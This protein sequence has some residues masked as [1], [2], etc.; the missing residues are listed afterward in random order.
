MATIT[1]RPG[2]ER[3]VIQRHPW[4]F[5]GAIAAV[6]GDPVGGEAVDVLAPTGDWLARG[7]WSGASQ[8][9]VRL[10]AWDPSQL[11]DEAWLRARVARAVSGR[12]GMADGEGGACRLVFSE[13]DGLPGLIVDRYGVYLVIQILTQGMEARRAEVLRALVDLLAPRGIFERSDN[14]M[15]EKESL[16]P[17][18][19]LLWGAEPPD[20]IAL[21]PATAVGTAVAP[22]RLLADLRAGQKTGFYLDQSVNRARVAAYCQGKQVLDC[23]AYS[24]GFSAYAA[25]AGAASLTLIDTSPAALDLARQNLALNQIATPADYV[26]GN[27]FKVLRAFRAEGRRFDVIILDPPKFANSQG[28][29]D[30]AARGYKDINWVAMQLLNPGGILATFSCSGLI[31]PDLFQKIVFGASV[32]AGR[33]VQIIE[34]LAQSP[35]HPV[36]L[37]FPESEYLKG[38][39]CRVW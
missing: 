15:R 12:V 25:R 5:S 30:H 29:V 31:S 11:L 2:R 28:Q 13:A 6:C 38:F 22:P 10:C 17:G 35:D 9:R 4:V 27:V 34:R 39:V 8:I 18:D 20:Q 23:F 3:P 19:G 14:D 21:L 16:P 26:E 33:D 36:L 7:L 32:D 24:G 1:L 37:T